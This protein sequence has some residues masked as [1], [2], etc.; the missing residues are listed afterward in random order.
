[1]E[2][3]IYDIYKNLEDP[4][5]RYKDGLKIK[6]DNE[7]EGTYGELTFYGYSDILKNI[8]INKNV[9]YD[10]YDLGSGTGKVIMYAALFG[11]F[12]NIIG[13]EYLKERHDIA[14]NAFSKLIDQEENNLNSHIYLIKG[15]LI[16][17][18]YFNESDYAVYFISNLCFSE[19]M[20]DKVSLLFNKYR[21]PIKGK[22][23]VIIC[24]KKFNKLKNFTLYKKI[25]AQMTW[26]TK[27]LVYIYESS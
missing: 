5:E 8:D 23:T 4:S 19:K 9:K 14:K 17:K 21:N 10:F 1:M 24:S 27:S 16:D 13:V 11:N 12:K 15:N 18:K 3:L 7:F 25:N 22:R 26:N 2:R 6:K 20:N